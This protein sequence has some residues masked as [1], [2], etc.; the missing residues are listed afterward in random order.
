MKHLRLIMILLAFVFASAS[1]EKGYVADD[2]DTS[3]KVEDGGDKGNQSSGDD[4]KDN[5]DSGGDIASSDTLSVSEFRTEELSDAVWV[6]GY[7]VGAATGA[8]KNYRYDFD[9]PFEF[10]TAIL[11]ADSPDASDVSEVISIQLKSGSKC[12]AIFNLVDNPE[13]KGK[14]CAFYG[15]KDVYLLIPGIKTIGSYILFS[16]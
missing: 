6:K 1:C 16:E 2:E 4:K 10:A 14:L 8:N 12:R 15:Y 5:D 11:I 13:N 7:I 9:A 3:E